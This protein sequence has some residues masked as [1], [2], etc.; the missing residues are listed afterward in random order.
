MLLEAQ[1]PFLQFLYLIKVDVFC[2]CI[3]FHE[4]LLFFFFLLCLDYSFLCIL[5]DEFLDASCRIDDFLPSREEWMTFGAEVDI[6]FFDCRPR[7]NFVATRT[8]YHAS[9]IFWMDF[10][11]HSLSPYYV[12]LIESRK[13]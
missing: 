4:W 11:S 3:V 10:F 13:S 1:K 6:D 2:S 5:L 7:F 8:G 12:P 9:H